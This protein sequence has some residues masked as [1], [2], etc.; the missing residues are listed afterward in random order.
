MASRAFAE[1]LCTCGVYWGM[2]EQALLTAPA[3]TRKT[4]TLCAS[5]LAQI[6]VCGVLIAVPL[7]YTDALPAFR[8]YEELK[9]PLFVEPPPPPV[10][11]S[12][13]V[14]A[15][16]RAFNPFLVPVTAPTSVPTRPVMIDR[17]FDAP[18]FAGVP[19]TTSGVYDPALTVLP[20]VAGPPP[21]QPRVEPK[22]PEPAAAPAAPIQVSSGVQAA[23][24]LKRVL[25]KYPRLASQTR[26]SGTVR[27]LAIIGTDG[28]I[29]KLDVL[30]GHPL[31]TQAAVD[32]VRQW[33]Y[34]PTIV[35]G[36]PVEVE[37]P[38]E[39]H[40]TLH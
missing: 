22:P 29:R 17:A 13:P 19:V 32:A 24:L 3:G 34:S 10:E 21:P 14:R 18:A 39:V 7:L 33:V 1:P 16:R 28:R 23:K 36:Q 38:I 35:S 6:S 37:A 5:F 2:F 15:A 25:P 20:S 4:G 12:T 30:E 40:F 31:L 8:G 9:P 26:T 27:L 11:R